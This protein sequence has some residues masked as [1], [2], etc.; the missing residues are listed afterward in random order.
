MSEKNFQYKK[1]FLK[2]KKATILPENIIFII[3]N[4]L[5][6]TV[7]I[8]FITR[9]GSG[10]VNLEESY[11]KQISLLID[12]ATPVSIIK[13]NMEKAKK[14]SEKNNL[15]FDEIIGVNENI[16][17]IKLSDDSGYTYSFFNDV[18]VTSYPEKISG[19]ETGNYIFTINQK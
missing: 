5:F 12:S 19:K 14:V 2:N 3:L 13:L 1:N 8:L 16:L 6:L 9:Q 7:L 18:D 17:T 15:N 4:L 11:A 10:I